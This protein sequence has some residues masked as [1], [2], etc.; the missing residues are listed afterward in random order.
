MALPNHRHHPEDYIEL[1]LTE[2][3]MK[4]TILKPI[5]PVDARMCGRPAQ[6]GDRGLLLIAGHDGEARDIVRAF[7]WLYLDVPTAEAGAAVVLADDGGYKIKIAPTKTDRVIG[8]T[9]E[10]GV[11]F[12]AATMW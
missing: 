9:L 7:E 11:L 5:G 6:R 2:P 3:V 4:G 10:G 12:S 1:I 8:E